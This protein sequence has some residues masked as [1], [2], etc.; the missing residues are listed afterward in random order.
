MGRQVFRIMSIVFISA[1]CFQGKAVAEE[2]LEPGTWEGTYFTHYGS[3]YKMDYIVS[4]GDDSTSSLKIKMINRD[5]EPESEFTYEL[6]SI[7]INEK[8]LT[9][10][11]HKKFG[12]EECTLQKDENGGYEGECRSKAGDNE[13]VCDITMVPPP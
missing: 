2:K 3:L 7:V 13:I 11:I 9:F 6:S 5:L 12:I 4:C 8:T 10:K 1:L